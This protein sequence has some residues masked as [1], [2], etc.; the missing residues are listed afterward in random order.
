MQK[1]KK[2]HKNSLR[3]AA[4]VWTNQVLIMMKKFELGRTSSSPFTAASAQKD[5]PR[6]AAD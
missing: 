6:A 4:Y 1:Y 3:N 2:L 5:F